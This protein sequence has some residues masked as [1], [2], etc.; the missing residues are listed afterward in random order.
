MNWSCSE[1]LQP[2]RQPST[3][4]NLVSELCKSLQRRKGDINAHQKPDTR[5][6]T[7]FFYPEKER[8][9]IFN[10][11]R[12]SIWCQLRSKAHLSNQNHACLDSAD[13]TKLLEDN[14]ASIHLQPPG[15]CLGKWTQCSIRAS[16]LMLKVTRIAGWTSQFQST[17]QWVKVL[18]R[19]RFW[20]PLNL[21]FISTSPSKLRSKNDFVCYSCNS[22]LVMDT[23]HW[24]S[25]I[26]KEV[27]AFLSLFPLFFSPCLARGDWQRALLLG[28]L[29]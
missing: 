9:D 20:G 27:M 16:P 11:H 22:A 3:W 26:I 7:F 25:F 14:Y 17:G 18:A 24:G 13:Q 21:C 1:S 10:T 29:P 5:K 23:L 19:L 4:K 28:A 2:H 8:N 12:P 6:H 15:R